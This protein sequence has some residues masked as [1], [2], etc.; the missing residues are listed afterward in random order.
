[1][2]RNFLGFILYKQKMSVDMFDVIQQAMAQAVNM[3]K[4]RKKRSV[5]LKKYFP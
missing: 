1:M 3:Q 4:E 5:E 2:L